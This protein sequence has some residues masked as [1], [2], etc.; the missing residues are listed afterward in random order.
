[1]TRES[2]ELTRMENNNSLIR[3]I[4]VIRGLICDS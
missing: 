2:H 4:R 3:M 1:M